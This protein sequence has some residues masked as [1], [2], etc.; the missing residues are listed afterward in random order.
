MTF[1][2][3]LSRRTRRR[4]FARFEHLCRKCANGTSWHANGRS[5]ECVHERVHYKKMNLN[6]LVGIRSEIKA[7][8]TGPSL[9]GDDPH[10]ATHACAS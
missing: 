9:G 2:Q 7:S 10:R 3:D 6:P 5:N 4:G 8:K 1:A